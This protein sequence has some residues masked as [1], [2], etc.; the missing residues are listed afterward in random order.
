[1]TQITS[2]C[3]HKAIYA[4]CTNKR[5]EFTQQL[6]KNVCKA[7]FP[8]CPSTTTHLSLF[9]HQCWSQSANWCDVWFLHLRWRNAER[10]SE[11]WQS[12]ST[13]AAGNGHH[14]HHHRISSLTAT[15][16]PPRRLP[17]FTVRE[18]QPRWAW[19]DV[20]LYFKNQSD[21]QT[22]MKW[23]GDNVMVWRGDL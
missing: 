10:N 20:Q 12:S 6:G 8:S 23:Q 2:C 3:H 15:E 19:E 16:L 11:P 18:K 1:M 21:R 17:V 13:H 5:N 14:C 4:Q 22:G 7:A 9:T